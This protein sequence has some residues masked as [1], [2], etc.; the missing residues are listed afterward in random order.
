MVES[1][2]INTQTNIST[3]ATEIDILTFY[4][5]DQGQDIIFTS[6]TSSVGSQEG[7]S[8]QENELIVFLKEDSF[9]GDTNILLNSDGELVIIS[10]NASQ[11]SIDSDGDLIF[12]F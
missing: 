8:F 11:Y 10:D 4:I 12:T 7:V 1:R 5:N 2:L 3:T 9:P 6:I